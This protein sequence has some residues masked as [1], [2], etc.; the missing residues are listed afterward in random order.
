M[1]DTLEQLLS[2]RQRAYYRHRV[3]I[4]KNITNQQMQEM[5]V[6]CEENCNG[7]WKA[8]NH[9]C[10]YFQFED[11]KDALMFSLRWQV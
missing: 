2:T 7:L 8:N 1:T 11:D 4:T 5:V 10:N 6:W 3:N 9:F